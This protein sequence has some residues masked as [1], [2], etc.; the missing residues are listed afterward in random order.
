[1]IS[2][3][4]SSLRCWAKAVLVLFAAAILEPTVDSCA[5]MWFTAGQRRARR[6]DYAP[7]GIVELA[8]FLAERCAGD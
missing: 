4:L 2:V 6:V 1:V 8:R 7:R 3:V 5:D